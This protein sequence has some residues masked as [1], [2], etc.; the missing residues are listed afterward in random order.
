MGLIFTTPDELAELAAQHE[1]LVARQRE[2]MAECEIVEKE[3]EG[4]KNVAYQ[5]FKDQ[6]LE[7]ER[8]RLAVA[9]MRLGNGP[10]DH[11]EHMKILGQFNQVELLQRKPDTL[12]AH[13]KQLTSHL[14]Q[15][16][17]DL[18]KVTKQINGASGARKD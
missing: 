14:R 16:A 9:R 13:L 4:Y 8:V 18:D 11:D 10:E 17:S 7:R 12:R 5:A 3:L 6:V 2:L 15:N 1:S